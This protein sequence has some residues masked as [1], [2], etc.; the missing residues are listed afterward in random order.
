MTTSTRRASPTGC[1]QGRLGRYFSTISARS[2]QTASR[3]MSRLMMIAGLV[4]VADKG[5]V[6]IYY[7]RY[8]TIHLNQST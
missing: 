2:Y 1:P 3:L 5:S 8:Y 4:Y 6:D 7:P